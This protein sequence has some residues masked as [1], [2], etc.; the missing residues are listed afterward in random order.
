MV[1]VIRPLDVHAELDTA[2]VQRS[3]SLFADTPAYVDQS[4]AH[5]P[6]Y[7]VASLA[8]NTASAPDYTPHPSPTERVLSRTESSDA[9]ASAGATT[10]GRPLPDEYVRKSSRLVLDMGRRVWASRIP[11]YGANASIAGKV[12]VK[13]SDHALDLCLTVSRNFN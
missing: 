6:A 1:Q 5:P 2:L 13:K 12:L 7:P 9:R 3:I 8:P 11:V 4:A 10:G